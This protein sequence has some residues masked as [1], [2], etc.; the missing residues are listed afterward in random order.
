MCLVVDQT[1]DDGQSA[2]VK[3]YALRFVAFSVEVVLFSE[4]VQKDRAPVT[5]IRLCGEMECLGLD[6]GVHIGKTGVKLLDSIPSVDC[7]ELR[8]VWCI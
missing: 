5:A 8:G 1:V 3:M 4:V 6:L 7:C 2:E